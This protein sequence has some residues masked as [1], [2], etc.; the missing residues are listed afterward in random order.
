MRCSYWRDGKF[1]CMKDMAMIVQGSGLCMD[2]AGEMMLAVYK[3][4][5]QRQM[6]A[7]INNY[8]AT[9]QQQQNVRKQVLGA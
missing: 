6:Y 3:N 7:N 2:H 9:Q 8:M 5:K 1:V 4:F